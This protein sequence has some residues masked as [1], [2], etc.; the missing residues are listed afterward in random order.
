MK[1]IL[2][3]LKPKVFRIIAGLAVKT[4]GT[5]MDLFIPWILAYM[6]DDVVPYNFLGGDNG[7]MFILRSWWK[8]NSQQN[9]ISCGEG[10]HS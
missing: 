5:V 6:I 10:H 7:N 4:T 2:K 9:G 8:R 3:Y 1:R